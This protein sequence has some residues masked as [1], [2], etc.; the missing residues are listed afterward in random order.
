MK[1]FRVV[2]KGMTISS[3]G[4]PHGDCFVVANDPTEAYNVVRKFIDDKD[5]GF[6]HER[7]LD[8]VE[9]LADTCHYSD[10]R[11]QLFLPK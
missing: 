2:L 10:V 11:K 7:E 5:F 4:T 6:S 8:R 3:T 9:L 1:L